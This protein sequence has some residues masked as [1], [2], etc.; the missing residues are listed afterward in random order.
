MANLTVWKFETE[1][2]ADDALKK[3]GELAKQHLII[4]LDAAVVSWP[5]GKK[6]P[7][8]RQAVNLVGKGLGH[9]RVSEDYLHAV[10][11]PRSFENPDGAIIPL[12][13]F[14]QKIG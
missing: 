9:R 13:V 5:T 3:L 14:F 6:H 12:E 11:N 8:T 2:G 7:K 10:P 1:Q 4:L